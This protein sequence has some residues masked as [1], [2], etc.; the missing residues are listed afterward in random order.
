MENRKFDYDV[1]KE[2]Q[3]HWSPRAYDDNH[4][5]LEEDLMALFEATRYAPSCVNEQPWRYI[6]A[7]NEAEKQK[8]IPILNASNASWAT[9]APVL[10]LILAKQTFNRNGKQ[11]RFHQFDAGT[12]WG[13]LLL[14][15]QR[16]GLI[17]HAMGGFDVDLARKIYLIPD[18]LTIIAAVAVGYYGDIDQLDVESKLAEH[19]SPR[20]SIEEI[21]YKY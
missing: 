18:D 12:S 14:E 11:N 8:F 5:V 16:R 3:E 21:L 9:K 15:A 19:P 7:R 10:F 13:F 17:T 1:L 2:I 4:S 20:L 6:L